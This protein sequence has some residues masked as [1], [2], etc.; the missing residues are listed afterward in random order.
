MRSF[1]PRNTGLSALLIIAALWSLS[2]SCSLLTGLRRISTPTVAPTPTVAATVAAVPQLAITL[3]AEPSATAALPA[4]QA[5]QAS[6]PQATQ[7]SAPQVVPTPDHLAAQAPWLVISTSDGIWMANPD[8]SW[9][10]QVSQAPITSPASLGPA[11]APDGSRLAYVTSNRDN[12][13]LDLSLHLLDL[14]SRKDTTLTALTSASTAANPQSGPG[15][16]NIEAARAMADYDSV[17]WSPDGSTLAFVGAQQGSSADIYTY[18]P[19]T[20]KINH[21]TSG[22]S[23][24]YA[25]SWSPDSQYIVHF[26]VA[27]FGTGA[28]YVMSGAWA[29]RASDGSVITLYTPNSGGEYLT[30][31]LDP[32]TFMVYSWTAA[33]GGESLRSINLASLAP[34]TVYSGCFAY[35]AMDPASKTVLLAGEDSSSCNCSPGKGAFLLKPGSSTPTQVLNDDVA[36]VSWYAPGQMFLA[37]TYAGRWV[38]ILPDGTQEFNV[39]AP[40]GKVAGII[41]GPVAWTEAEPKQEAG[42]WVQMPVGAPRKIFDQPATNPL[43]TSDKGDVLVFFSGSDLYAAHAPDF[44]PVKMGQISGDVKDAA[45]AK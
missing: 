30:G 28:G 45:M 29:V 19:A 3:P 17:A 36:Q 39:S 13:Y 4:P 18:V 5:T 20:G 8:G 34:Q 27:G 9:L 14:A 42:V 37:L 32:T 26:G 1:L 22:P 12:S 41:D 7:A 15:D 44:T 38:G 6:S 21:L 23:Q 10:T 2:V 35:A 25:P 31:W 24:A 40:N 11:I 16:N 43:W 33:C